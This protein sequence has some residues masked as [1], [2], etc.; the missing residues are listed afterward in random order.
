MVSDETPSG[1]ANVRMATRSTI[2]SNAAGSGASTD[3]PAST[4]TAVS[5]SSNA[6]WTRSCSESGTGWGYRARNCCTVSTVSHHLSVVAS[7]AVTGVT[8]VFIFLDHGRDRTKHDRVLHVHSF[9][10]VSVICDLGVESLPHADKR[11]QNRPVTSRCAVVVAQ[12][13]HG[14][15][16]VGN[17]GARH[18]TLRNTRCPSHQRVRARMQCHHAVGI[19]R[20]GHHHA[21]AVQVPQFS[22]SQRTRITRIAG[23]SQ[24]RILKKV[25]LHV[26]T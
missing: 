13:T 22:G 1:L 12:G 7:A 15:A 14:H 18:R 2:G 19:N 20:W 6:A 8:R 5:A 4:R 10:T 17:A 11:G 9:G 24:V 25:A 21:E 3:S 16:S 23:A 26:H